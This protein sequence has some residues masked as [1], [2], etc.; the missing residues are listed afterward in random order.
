M[1]QMGLIGVISKGVLLLVVS[2]LFCVSCMNRNSSKRYSYKYGDI[3]KSVVGYIQNDTTVRSDRVKLIDVDCNYEFKDAGF[4][5]RNLKLIPLEAYS[6]SLIGEVDKIVVQDSFIYLLDIH[7]AKSLFVFNLYTGRFIRKIGGYGKSNSEYV[8]PTDFTVTGNHVVILDN[9]SKKLLI[10]GTEGDFK[11]STRLQYA[12]QA[13]ERT[14]VDSIFMGIAG[15]NRHIEAIHKYKILKFDTRGHILG[16]YLKMDFSMNFYELNNLKS[17]SNYFWYHAPFSNDV[18]F[19]NHLGTEVKYKFRFSKKGIPDNF[20]EQCEGN[21]EEFIE[22]FRRT[23]SYVQGKCC[24]TGRYLVFQYANEGRAGCLVIYDM[25]SDKVIFNGVPVFDP[26]KGT[27]EDFLAMRLGGVDPLFTE[28]SDR[29]Y[30]I[31]PSERLEVLRS[32]E[33]VKRSFN[34][35]SMISNNNPILFIADIESE[36]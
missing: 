19:L 4:L 16:K 12:L 29:V 28:K 14:D 27:I 31:I 26:Q 7:R 23:Y 18:V 34:I 10:F 13:I 8:E 35:D 9:L 11:R 2:V 21:Y 6:N 1:R 5:I 30:G 15:D 20:D 24:Y 22:K 3:D 17:E 32:N 25:L 36:K 33:E